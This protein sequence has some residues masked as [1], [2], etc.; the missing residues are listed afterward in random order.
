MHSLRTLLRGSSGLDP[1]P[2]CSRPI[3][4]ALWPILNLWDACD[5]HPHSW[6]S[7][8]HRAELLLAWFATGNGIYR[9]E[10]LCLPHF[11]QVPFALCI[12]TAGPYGASL[13][14]LRE[15]PSARITIH[16]WQSREDVGL[17]ATAGNVFSGHALTVLD[18][19]TGE[20][21][22]FLLKFSTY[23]PGKMVSEEWEEPGEREYRSC[24]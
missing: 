23:P 6:E 4:N 11:W 18:T 17:K 13:S 20:C 21:A 14:Y 2:V 10:C 24:L 5:Q 16:G 8:S 1:G 3:L 19:W 22:H 12:P 9:A 7:L 15:N